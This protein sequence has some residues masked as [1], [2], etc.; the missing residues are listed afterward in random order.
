MN[1]EV[2]WEAP[3]VLKFFESKRAIKNTLRMNLADEDDK[4]HIPTRGYGVYIFARR[5]GN[6]HY[7]PLYIGSTENFKSRITDRFQATY[8]NELR[9]YIESTPKTDK[10]LFIG[11]IKPQSG[12]QKTASRLA[13]SVLIYEAIKRK[14]WSK[15][16]NKK[17]EKPKVNGKITF[18]GCS[19]A[20]RDFS[21]RIRRVQNKTLK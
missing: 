6:G 9:E 17:F 1:I 12:C 14:H 3:L 11:K 19:L 5:M 10:A 8:H 4:K 20:I 16:F 15:L 2:A 13:E 18:K 21:G 7:V